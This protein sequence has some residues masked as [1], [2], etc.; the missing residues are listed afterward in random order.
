MNLLF[1]VNNVTIYLLLSTKCPKTRK[2]LP[3][4]VRSF[5]LFVC[6][7]DKKEPFADSPPTPLCPMFHARFLYLYT[8]SNV[9]GLS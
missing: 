9:I 2:N 5:R 6:F 7:V 8:M 1:L 3:Y 4:G